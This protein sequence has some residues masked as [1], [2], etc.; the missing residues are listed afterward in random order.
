MEII[1]GPQ[2]ICQMLI[3]KPQYTVHVSLVQVQVFVKDR[4]DQWRLDNRETCCYH[5]V[6]VVVNRTQ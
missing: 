4:I 1:P 6:G 5:L 3:S 2:N